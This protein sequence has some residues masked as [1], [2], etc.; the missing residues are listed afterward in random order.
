M[1]D[2]FR[3]VN[4][5]RSFV[6][7]FVSLLNATPH[8]NAVNCNQHA[9]DLSQLQDLRV[10]VMLRDCYATVYVVHNEMHKLMNVVQNDFPESATKYEVDVYDEIS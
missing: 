8:L 1:L 4:I 7:S 3:H 2:T 5:I 10:N 9:Q 6:R